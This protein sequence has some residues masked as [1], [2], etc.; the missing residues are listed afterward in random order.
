MDSNKQTPGV[1][2]IHPAVEPL[3][4]RRLLSAALVGG[5]L[6]IKGSS[7]DDT[8][9]VRLKA[10]NS[11]LI[12][13]NDNGNLKAFLTSSVSSILMYSS[14]G[15]DNL[16][17]DEKFGALDLSATLSGG[18]G[19]DRLVGGSGGDSIDGDSGNDKLYGN[20]GFDTL[21]GDAD[22]D[23]L[24]GGDGSD[25]LDGDL[26]DDYLDGSAHGDTLEGDFGN[27]LLYG[28]VGNDSID[29]DEGNDY[30]SGGSGIDDVSGDEGTDTI[31]GGAGPDFFHDDDSSS[32]YRDFDAGEG[33]I[34]T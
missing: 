16:L 23:T 26:G 17:I 10:G 4:R 11:N 33:D 9:I 32:E 7:G 12:Q 6:R 21:D 20:S 1:R 31:Y 34:I 27:D 8:L 18:A 3:E 2:S 5:Q 28:N 14:G 24:V 15:N 25:S 29:G 13:V 30:I 19:N 22:N